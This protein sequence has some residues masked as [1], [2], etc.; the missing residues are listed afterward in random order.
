MPFVIEKAPAEIEAVSSSRKRARKSDGQGAA[1]NH[2]KQIALRLDL[3]H[4]RYNEALEWLCPG[5]DRF[6]K[7]M[8]GEDVTYTQTVT[9]RKKLGKLLVKIYDGEGHSVVLDLSNAEPK[10]HNAITF[11]ARGSTRFMPLKIVGSVSRDALPMLDDYL[12]ASVL[13]DVAVQQM[14]LE[15]GL[16]A[17]NKRDAKAKGRRGAPLQLAAPGMVAEEPPRDAK[18]RAAGE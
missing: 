9:N 3:S 17:Q 15:E 10:G 6:A 7:E 8:S 1:P 13:V 16:R 14:D 12:S 5:C 11:G 18:S 4:D 2:D